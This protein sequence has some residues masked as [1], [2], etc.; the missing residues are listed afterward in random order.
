MQSCGISD[1]GT[2]PEVCVEIGQF[3]RSSMES[4]KRPDAAISALPAGDGEL[5]SR[6]FVADTNS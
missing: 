1:V 5:S 4:P 6:I 3:D 2:T